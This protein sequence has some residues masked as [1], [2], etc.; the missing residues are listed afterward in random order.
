MANEDMAKPSEEA[1][2]QTTNR[3]VPEATVNGIDKVNPEKSHKRRTSKKSRKNAQKI[4][5]V[6]RGGKLGKRAKAKNAADLDDDSSDTSSSQAETDSESDSDFSSGEQD[7][8]KKSR[9]GRG[10]MGGVRA[11]DGL[12]GKTKSKPSNKDGYSSDSS[13]SDSDSESSD[14]D[15]DADVQNGQ[16]DNPLVQ[17]LAQQIRDLQLQFTQL[18][19]G[20]VAPQVS[21]MPA[22]QP[23]IQNPPTLPGLVPVRAPSH[24]SNGSNQQRIGPSQWTAPGRQNPRAG[25]RRANNNPDQAVIASSSGHRSTESKP[26]N[27]KQKQGDPSRPDFKRV[28]WVWD[29]TNYSYKLQDSVETST[30]SQYDGYVFHVRRIFD[31]DGKYRK[32]SI[33][34]KSKLLREVLQDVMGNPK[35]VSLVDETPKLDPNLLFLYLDDFRA[36]L[37]S[38]RK[39]EPAGKSKK[40]R[41]KNQSR[42]DDKRKQL[43][44]LIK[45]LDTDYDKIKSSLDPML[46]NGLITFDL[47]WALWKP[48]TLAYSSTYGNLDM[49]RVFKVEA[50]ERHATIHKGEFYYLDGK[51]FEFDGKR[52]GFGHVSEEIS[53]FKGARK[54]TSLPCYPLSYCSDE[55]KVRDRLITRGRKFVTLS[56]MHYKAYNGM[57]FMKRKKAIIRF[58]V[59]NSRIMIDPATFR[60]INPNYYV[61][62]VR[63]KDPDAFGE[64]D[65]SSDDD[66]SSAKCGSSDSS[67]DDAGLKMVT[68]MVKDPNGQLRMVQVPRN[69][70]IEEKNSKHSLTALP[71]EDDEAEE[72][73]D[74]KETE[75]EEKEGKTPP[76]DDA[77][78]EDPLVTIKA[79]L[80]DNEYLLASPVVLGFSFSEKQWL[81]F[82]VD[83]VADIKW[84]D[85]A[86]DSLV[87]ETET[88][89]L[90][91]ALVESRKYNPATTIDD[92]IQGKGKGLVGEC[93]SKQ[94]YERS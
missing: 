12:T 53:E 56:G 71:Q 79:N 26:K 75:E 6:N 8:R 83:D 49:P 89:R 55:A 73:K 65:D 93:L 2:D 28:D 66:D 86:W 81:E 10:K 69:Q 40:Q 36:H 38:L 17:D 15:V 29:T 90:I 59:Q 77:E 94:C 42:L 67:D 91:K 34:I 14:D 23:Q 20:Y 46:R 64:D 33:D 72:G 82:S 58:N 74:K 76:G 54:I 61:S 13:S 21:L 63:S 57:A 43:K 3:Q 78:D 4:S 1:D 19:Q 51:Y 5:S 35:G 22:A 80:T 31:P 41:R 50:A 47:L 44:V 16:L 84:N 70:T 48:G 27:K 25:R 45:Y 52:F 39:L 62:Q 7:P 18:Q 9:Q 85:K 68:R 32:T 30:N 87:L 37:K 92:V 11:R 60:R 88:K 24:L